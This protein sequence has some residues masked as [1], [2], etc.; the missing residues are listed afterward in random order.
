MPKQSSRVRNEIRNEQGR[1]NQ[2]HGDLLSLLYGDLNSGGAKER[3]DA[4]FDTAFSG[5]KNLLGR[6]PSAYDP[7]F[8]NFATTGGLTDE[9]R[10]RIRGGGVFDEA[11]RTGLVSEG[12]KSSLRAR[13]ARQAPAFF[14]ALKDKFSTAAQTTGAGPSYT[15]SLSRMARDQSRAASDTALDTELDIMDRVNEGRRWGASGMSGSETGLA[16]L[17]SANK[18]F[19]IEGGARNELA[20]KGLDLE[21]LRG[22][23]GLR[24]STPGE[25]FG[26]Y[27]MILN[28]IGSRAGASRGNLGLRTSYDPNVSWFDRLMA[29]WGQ[30]S[31]NAQAAGAGPFL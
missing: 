2:E 27:D 14:D 29:I 4:T 9:N 7:M 12:D 17:E 30:A 28:T 8:K 16:G 13:G 10:R 20:N 23:V 3:G 1:S 6:G 25:Q 5:F 24:S 21:A 18:R 22:I 26:L 19:G 11:A 31:R 15:S